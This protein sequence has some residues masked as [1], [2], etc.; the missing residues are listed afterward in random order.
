MLTYRLTNKN[1]NLFL[2]NL[3]L[4]RKFEQ[5]PSSHPLR[6]QILKIYGPLRIHERLWLSGSN[7]R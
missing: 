6:R 3:K 7:F 5:L 1:L 4:R 2:V